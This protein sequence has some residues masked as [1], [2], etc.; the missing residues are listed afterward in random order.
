MVDIREKAD[1]LAGY[2]LMYMG[3]QTL[4]GR[5]CEDAPGQLYLEPVYLYRIGEQK[6]LNPVTKE[7][8]VRPIRSLHPPFGFVEIQRMDVASGVGVGV[9]ELSQESRDALLSLI[10]EYEEKRN[11]M[12]LVRLATRSDIRRAMR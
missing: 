6:R 1:P 7:E 10:V 4:L 2:V 8:E 3:A 12:G 11:A 9:H 5:L